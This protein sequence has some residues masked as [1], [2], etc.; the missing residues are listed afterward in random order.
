MSK[1]KAQS[2]AAMS[3]P[4]LLKPI[5]KEDGTVQVIIETPK[6]SH[7]KFAF[8]TKQRIFALK[9]VLP[10]GM[11][12]P[13]DFGFLPR[14]LAGDG[15][16][17]DVLL[18]MDEPAYPGVA[19]EARLIGVIE[20][21]QL[22]GKKKTRNDR[23]VAVASSNHMYANIRK[24]SDI[25]KESLRELQDFFVNYHKLEG[26][27]YRLLGCK[28]IGTALRLIKQARKAAS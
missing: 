4:T 21:E 10:A 26:L 2:R 12:F 24:L 15:D 8:D 1:K 17:I 13:Y 3:D 18:L 25:P 22:D 23:L 7:N 16:A 14:T 5:N 6:G 11:V 19:V 28:G 9:S 20:G 27:E